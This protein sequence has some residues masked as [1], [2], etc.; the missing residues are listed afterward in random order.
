MSSIRQVLLFIIIIVGG[1]GYWLWLGL[2]VWPRWGNLYLKIPENF[3]RLIL[4][5]V[6]TTYSNGQI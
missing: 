2:V 3:V 1:G 5:C 6:Y 4:G